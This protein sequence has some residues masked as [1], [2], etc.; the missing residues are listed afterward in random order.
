MLLGKKVAFPFRSCSVSNQF[1]TYNWCSARALIAVV[2]VTQL[3]L[4]NL[5]PSI[6]YWIASECCR[7]VTTHQGSYWD[8]FGQACQVVR[9]QPSILRSV[10]TNRPLAWRS[11]ASP[12]SHISQELWIYV[13]TFLQTPIRLQLT[14]AAWNFNIK[15]NASLQ[16]PQ[17]QCCRIH[18]LSAPRS[19]GDSSPLR[20]WTSDW[21]RSM[22]TFMSY[23][24]CRKATPLNRSSN[25]SIRSIDAFLPKRIGSFSRL[26]ISF[27][28]LCM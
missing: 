6:H 8:L 14:R 22:L 28:F 18:C 17:S 15:F 3:L 9:R 20:S 13:W 1:S 16:T 4:T 19:N 24:E 7:I 10:A 2:S 27:V 5:T 25:I 23:T 21:L 11:V 26:S 12:I